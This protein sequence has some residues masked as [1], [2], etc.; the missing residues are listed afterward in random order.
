[1]TKWKTIFKKT[2]TKFSKKKI[3]MSICTECKTQGSLVRGSTLCFNCF[4]REKDGEKPKRKNKHEEDDIQ[5]AFFQSVRLI[6]PQLGKLI[7]AVPNG[8]RRNKIEAAR[9]KKQGVEPG[10]ADILC[11]VPNGKFNFLC[12]ETKTQKGKQSE[13]QKDFQWQ[14]ERA[15]GRYVIFRSAEEGIKILQEYL[16]TANINK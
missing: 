2:E 4:I 10:V 15:G 7:F 3:I 14:T 12:L 6:F 8:G 9:M 5:E 13:D 11:L 1:M 16:K